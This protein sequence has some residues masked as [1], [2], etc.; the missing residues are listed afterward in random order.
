MATGFDDAGACAAEVKA[1][2]EIYPKALSLSVLLVTVLYVL[3]LAVGVAVEPDTRHWHDGHLAVVGDAVGGAPL[4]LALG[5]GG[6]ASALAQLNALLCTSVR[7]IICLA[8]QEGQPVPRCRSW[9]FRQ[10]AFGWRFMGFLAVSSQ[11]EAG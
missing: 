3:P 2:K 7:E 10:R 1:P 5:L 9:L 8:D 11:L 6:F 4:R